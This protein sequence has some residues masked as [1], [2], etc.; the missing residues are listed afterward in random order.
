M[1]EWKKCYGAGRMASAA[2]VLLLAAGC[3]FT[4]ASRHETRFYDLDT[5]V[6]APQRVISFGMLNNAT[7]ARQ[8]MLYRRTGGQVTPDEYNLWIQSPEQLLARY[9]FN[10]MPPADGADAE[11]MLQVRGV[12]TAFEIDLEHRK[13]ILGMRY[14]FVSRGVRRD[15]ALVCSEPFQEETPEAF[16]AA[17]SKCAGRVGRDLLKVGET[18]TKTGAVPEPV[19]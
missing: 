9:W 12:L 7:P 10:M 8:R 13:V 6:G 5:P 14:E 15:G 19:Q 4:Q 1:M 17:F 11:K 16:A 2:G 18:L 3:V